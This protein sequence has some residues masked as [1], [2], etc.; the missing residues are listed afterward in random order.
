FYKRGRELAKVKN[1]IKTLGELSEAL[2][3]LDEDDGEA[4]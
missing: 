1:D 3:I 2:L 4:W